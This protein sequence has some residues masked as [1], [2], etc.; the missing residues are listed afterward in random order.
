MT[1]SGP[2]DVIRRLCVACVDLLDVSGAGVSLMTDG[3]GGGIVA[4]SG[5]LAFQVEEWQFS[6][7]EG[8][9]KDAYHGGR[10]IIVGDVAG[11]RSG[12]VAYW[13]VFAD[14]IRQAG[15]KAIFAFP[16]QV[17]GATVGVL[18]LFRDLPGLLSSEQVGVASAFADLAGTL[19]PSVLSG[20]AEGI[21]DDPGYRLE[22]HQA[23]GMVSGQLG[24][25]VSEALLRLRARAFGDGR[26][27][28]E[29]AADVIARL[30]RFDKEDR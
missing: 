2:A 1:E 4:A 30:V 15:I 9:C 29:L 28:S 7:G 23:T 24:V 3:A 5:D 25:S 8:P 14:L 6:L 26:T 17:T 22:V 11:D 13:P 10:P 19:L 16:L 20:H 18:D 21:G 12:R 27:V